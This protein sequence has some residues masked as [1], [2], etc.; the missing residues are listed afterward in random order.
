MPVPAERRA[1]SRFS[2]VAAFAA[3]YLV[4]GSTYLAIRIAI[5]T[6]PPFLMAGTRFLLA[7]TLLYGVMRLRGEPRPA[8]LH[9]RSAAII[10]GFMLLG[11]NGGVTWAEQW[12]TSGVAA[13]IA[14][15]VPLWMVLID[16]LRP[17]GVRPN[18]GVVAGLALGLAGMVLLVGLGA[19]GSTGRVDPAGAGA[20]I[21][22][23]VLWAI[24][25]LY[26]RRARLPASH[27]QGISM[28][29]LAGGALLLLAGT[30]TGEWGRLDLAAISTRSLLAV[31]YLLLFGSLIGFSS[32]VWLLQVTTVA[33]ASTYAYVNPVVAVFLGWALAGEPLTPRTLIAAAVIVAAVVIITTYRAQAAPPQPPQTEHM[34]AK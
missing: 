21:L 25:S 12:V 9:W 1:P 5:E 16:W 23:G 11:G 22:A 8:R 6:L 7:G 24:G 28:E 4:W 27:L 33:R 34:R 29:M 18:R 31:G 30:V 20:L 14:A 15:M 13:L 26:S 2:L 19:P 17:G 3:V 10:G 32:Y